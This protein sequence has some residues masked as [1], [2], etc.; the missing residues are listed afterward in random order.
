ML[1]VEK[2]RLLDDKWTLL[3]VKYPRRLI[4]IL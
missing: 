1:L 2:G 3:K 4:G